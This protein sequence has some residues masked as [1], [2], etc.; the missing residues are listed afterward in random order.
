MKEWKEY[1]GHFNHLVCNSHFILK[2]VAGS[3]IELGPAV[4]DSSPSASTTSKRAPL[5]ARYLKISK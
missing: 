1:E 4:T 3:G 5:S 2:Y